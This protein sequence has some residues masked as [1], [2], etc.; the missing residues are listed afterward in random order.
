[1]NTLKIIYTGEY[2]FNV[3]EHPLPA[4]RCIPDWYKQMKEY[5]NN[6]STIRVINRVTNYTAKKCVPMLDAIISGYTVP[7]PVDV[8]VEQTETFGPTI[9]WKTGTEVFE[10]HGG[11]S[12]HT[13]PP[14]PGYFPKVFKLNAN[15]RIETPKGT[16][17]LINQPFGHYNLPF[18]ALPAIID[19]DYNII[20]LNFPV[21]VKEG[22]TGVVGKGTPIVQ[23]TPFQRSDWKLETTWETEKDYYIREEKGF[24]SNI[25]NNYLRNIRQKKV[26]ND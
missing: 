20:N 19:T 11:E 25:I 12:A 5:E 26:Y 13:I 4:K 9:S 6:D 22:Y 21:W 18:Y 24:S 7:L 10:V 15:F 14:P 3:F 2:S 17:I 23:I 8:L 16:S 1:M